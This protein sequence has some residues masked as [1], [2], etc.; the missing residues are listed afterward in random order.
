[1]IGRLVGFVLSEELQSILMDVAGVGYELVCPVG[2]AGRAR[3]GEDGR[4]ELIVHTHLRQDALELFG[5]ASADERLAFRQLCSVPGV[6]PRLALAVLSALSVQD[7]AEILRTEDK[8]RLTKV[9]GIGKKTAERLVLELR[10]KLEPGGTPA[11]TASLGAGPGARP[12]VTEK[13][14]LA[15]TGLGYKASEAERAAK[16]VLLEGDQSQDM[17]VLLR[18]A[19]QA[20]SS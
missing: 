4:T 8:V 16:V 6:G 2:T 14:V 20:I 19:L 11:A 9:P 17:A 1:M 15:L 13:L 5:F 10:G 12:S 18:R 7:L 3:H